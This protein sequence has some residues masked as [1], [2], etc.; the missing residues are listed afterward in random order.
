MAG[1]PPVAADQQQ[2]DAPAG[3]CTQWSDLL[4]GQDDRACTQHARWRRSGARTRAH[5]G[6]VSPSSTIRDCRE[7]PANAFC[8]CAG[9]SASWRGCLWLKHIRNQIC[10]AELPVRHEVWKFGSPYTLVLAKADE[11]FRRDAEAR[12]DAAASLGWLAAASDR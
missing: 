6:E 5:L 2:R 3:R 1:L 12:T 7:T 8:A 9:V 11:L 4:L 10:A